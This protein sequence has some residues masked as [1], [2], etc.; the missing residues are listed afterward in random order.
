M[1]RTTII[2]P[3]PSS[4]IPATQVA[5][6]ATETIVM[7]PVP[8]PNP[9]LPGVVSLPLMVILPAQIN[10]EKT[11]FDIIMAGTITT[12]AASTIIGKIYGVPSAILQAGTAATLG[13][14]TVLSTSGTTTQNSTTAPF[15]FH[16]K[17]VIFDS[18]SGKLCGKAGWLINNVLSA[19]A[20]FSSI[21]TAINSANDPVL[22][23]L[24]TLTLSGG[25]S[26]LVTQFEIG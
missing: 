20:A 10:L 14:D 9:L 13:N 25:G 8:T 23:F 7:N 26:A 16:A 12:A 4:A 1:S 15:V 21:M 11:A 22:G 17:D 24:A 19:D 18:T 5:A 2:R 6:A 3:T